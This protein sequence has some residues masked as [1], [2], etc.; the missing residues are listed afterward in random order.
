MSE[1]MKSYFSMIT[2][3]INGK[4]YHIQGVE[5]CMTLAD[6]LREK[7]GLIGDKGCL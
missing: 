1:K 4:E 6:V 5:S 2:L 7:H 3:N